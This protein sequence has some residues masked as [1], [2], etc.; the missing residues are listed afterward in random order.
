[1]ASLGQEVL[2]TSFAVDQPDIVSECLT[3]DQEATPKIKKMKKKKKVK[4]AVQGGDYP[5][6]GMSELSDPHAIQAPVPALDMIPEPEVESLPV[7][8]LELLE[9]IPEAPEAAPELPE[10]IPVPEEVPEVPESQHFVYEHDFAMRE[11]NE[12]VESK[13]TTE[14]EVTHLPL[15]LPFAAQ[16]RLMIHL[17]HGLE[18]IC[19]SFGQ[20]HM[21]EKLRAEGW[22]CPEAVEL[23]IWTQEFRFAQYFKDRLP[24]PVQRRALLNS[25]ANIRNYAVSRTRIDFPEMEKI[26]ASAAELAIV[27]GEEGSIFEKLREDVVSTNNWLVEETGQLQKRF[28]AKLNIFATARA[29][30]DA[31]EEGT[32]AAFEKGLL[33]RQNT[34]HAKVLM[35][36]ERAEADQLAE[37]I[38]RSV[39]PSSLDWVNGLENSLM[40]GDD[41]QEEGLV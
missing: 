23:N 3:F 16:H 33:K 17:Q 32:R 41:S 12:L 1:M 8:E 24:E 5:S 15:Y 25:V 7:E 34:A 28:D 35:A 30:V 4:G 21:P 40:L 31:L 38:D 11:K 10:D 37:V 6:T 29:K 20:R 13:V 14:Q 18:A 26:L 39:A 27:L 9:N 22:D 2:Q 36:I 19:F